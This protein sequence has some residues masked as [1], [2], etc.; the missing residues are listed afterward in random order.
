MSTPSQ[1][2]IEEWVMQLLR[3]HGIDTI[4]W[5]DGAVGLL[6]V[7][8]KWNGVVHDMTV[9]LVSV[10]A[11]DGLPKLLKRGKGRHIT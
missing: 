4:R 5:N 7:P 11:G 1:K 8:T 9:G 10:A 6:N 3:G 2:T